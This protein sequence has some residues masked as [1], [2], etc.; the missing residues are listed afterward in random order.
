MICMAKGMSPQEINA[1]RK[2]LTK[3]KVMWGTAFPEKIA[4]RNQVLKKLGNSWKNLDKI[5]REREV[6]KETFKRRHEQ[7][8]LEMGI[9]LEN[10]GK[11]V[12]TISKLIADGARKSDHKII[13]L[14]IAALKGW[15]SSR[16]RS[17]YRLIDQVKHNSAMNLDERKYFAFL[18]EKELGEVKQ[19]K[20]AIEELEE[21]IS[22]KPF[23]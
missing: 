14:G 15:R 22:K 21:W 2:R 8:D 19:V 20:G 23:G 6:L 16:M 1:L 11:I 5:R 17:L 4:V 13:K 18:F 12:G 3:G 10:S 7:L 9:N